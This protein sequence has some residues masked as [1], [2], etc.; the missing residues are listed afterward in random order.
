MQETQEIQETHRKDGYQS[1]EKDSKVNEGYFSFSQLLLSFVASPSQN[2]LSIVW[3]CW[4]T[5]L[6]R[7]YKYFQWYTYC[8]YS[9]FFMV[10]TAVHSIL[11]VLI[12]QSVRSKNYHSTAIWQIHSSR[13]IRQTVQMLPLTSCF[14]P[15]CLMHYGTGV[16]CVCVLDIFVVVSGKKCYPAISSY[17]WMNLIS[18]W[19]FFMCDV[20]DFLF[21]EMP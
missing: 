21:T 6:A 16:C 15:S 9:P 5:F 13:C 20:N 2:H 7:H 18:L 4:S 14:R 11:T 12:N 8:Y 1:K 10:I 17:L 19:D 3:Y